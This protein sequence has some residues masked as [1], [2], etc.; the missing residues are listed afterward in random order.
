VSVQS[1]KMF[2]EMTKRAH[3]HTHF[4]HFHCPIAPHSLPLLVTFRS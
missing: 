3:T 2:S 4:A 1:V